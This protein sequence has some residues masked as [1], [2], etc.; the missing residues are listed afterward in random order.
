VF[1]LILCGQ[2]KL[3]GKVRKMIG[4]TLQERYL[5][6]EKLGSGGF[7]ETYLAEYPTKLS[8]PQR[9]CVVK[10][11]KPNRKDDSDMVDSFKHEAEILT[12][13]GDEHD[14]IPRYIDYFEENRDFYIVQ[15]YI[16]GHDLTNDITSG[17][18][19]SEDEVIELLQG[20]LKVLAY[21]HEQGVIHK[22]IKPSNIM[23]RY[24]DNKL[25]LIDFGAVKEVIP[26]IENISSTNDIGTLS[27]MPIEQIDGNPQLASDIYSLGRM[28]IQALTGLAVDQ[29]PKHSW[30]EQVNVT[31][32]LADILAKMVQPNFRHRYRDATE[33]LN[34]LKQTT[35][36]LEPLDNLPVPFQESGK[37]GY[38]TRTGEVVIQAQFTSA[39]NF[40]EGLA[41]VGLGYHVGYIDRTG[42]I[43]IY[44][45]YSWGGKFCE[46]LARVRGE[47][48][49]GYINKQGN[50]I[51]KQQL[52]G[53]LDFGE[54]FAP[55]MIK[56]KWGYMNQNGEIVIEPQFDEAE[57]FY[58]GLA[59]VRNGWESHTIDKAGNL[60]D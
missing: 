20:V 31:K 12:R 19:W 53:G 7:G 10:L 56:N 16:D 13:L 59:R 34:A 1:P 52:D 9:K 29:I 2:E 11:L 33:A 45:T 36:E 4:T 3:T 5:L 18:P 35:A 48:T 60:I 47:K 14:Q 54:G 15:E 22:D 23:R 26:G 55:V 46:G 32:W 24:S 37:W 49:F 42:K 40:S 58:N 51:N 38:E 57:K 43:V 50:P 21:V 41:R 30:C 17:K 25:I 28:A 27:Y 39:Q 44:P 8:V 6:K